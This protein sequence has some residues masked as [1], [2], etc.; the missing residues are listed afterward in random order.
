VLE[1][2]GWRGADRDEAME[3]LVITVGGIG[4]HATFEPG[5]WP[6]ERQLAHL[7][8]VVGSLRR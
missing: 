8:R 4:P 5:N 1:R 3:A 7:D 2:A 6:P